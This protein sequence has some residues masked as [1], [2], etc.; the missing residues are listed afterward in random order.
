MILEGGWAGPP[1]GRGFPEAGGEVRVSIRRAGRLR[2]KK[3]EDIMESYIVEG[4]V[5]MKI[6]A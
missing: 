6:H 4:N 1:G 2:K 3:F 5:M